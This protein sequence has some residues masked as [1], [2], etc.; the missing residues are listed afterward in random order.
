MGINPI[1]F[2][3]NFTNN[4][5]SKK[6][7]NKLSEMEFNIVADTLRNKNLQNNIDFR[8]KKLKEDLN[9]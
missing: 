6:S 5:N 7:H 9:G 4:R 2:G 8:L 1:N 3:R